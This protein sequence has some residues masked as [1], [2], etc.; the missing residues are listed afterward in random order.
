MLII[1]SVSIGRIAT[2]AATFAVGISLAPA[3]EA[4]RRTDDRSWM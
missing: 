1:P 2:L 4:Q 3:A